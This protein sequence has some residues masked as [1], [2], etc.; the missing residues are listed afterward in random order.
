MRPFASGL[1]GPFGLAFDGAG[2]LYAAN[3]TSST[4]SKITP[5]GRVQTF[6]TGLSG[7]RGIAFDQEGYLYAANATNSTIG[8]IGPD[9]S[10]TTF[11]SGLN[12]PEGLS[13]DATGNLYVT[14]A[15]NDTISLVAPEWRGEGSAEDRLRR[16][17][18]RLLPHHV[19][20]PIAAEDC[21]DPAGAKGADHSAGR[22][23]RRHRAAHRRIRWL[24][25][26]EAPAAS[27]ARSSA[28][29]RADG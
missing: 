18:T 5:Q 25:Q 28:R 1:Q 17:E 22:G 15:G 7:P 21:D 12:S 27:A 8:K 3:F 2:N 26:A 6:A 23:D 20:A 19:A 14:N 16:T 4:I 10:V 11:A 9:G 29:G 13:F 24:L